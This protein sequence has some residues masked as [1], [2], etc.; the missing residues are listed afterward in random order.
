MDRVGHMGFIE[1]REKTFLAI[2]HFAERL[3]KKY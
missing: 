2:E 1:A 3:F